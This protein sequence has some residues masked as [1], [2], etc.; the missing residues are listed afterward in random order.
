M[1]PTSHPATDA[2]ASS[3][4]HNESFIDRITRMLPILSGSRL[5]GKRSRRCSF[6]PASARIRIAFSLL[7]AM[8]VIHSL[9]FSRTVTPSFASDTQPDS[10]TAEQETWLQEE[11]LQKIA[12]DNK[13]TVAAINYAYLDVARIWLNSVQDVNATNFALIALDVNAYDALILDYPDNTFMPPYSNL[14]TVSKPVMHGTGEFRTVTC[15]RPRFLLDFLDKG[16]TVF[17]S[18]IDSIWRRNPW[19]VY[20]NAH[21]NTVDIAYTLDGK[22][23]YICSCFL[24]LRPT[25]KTKAAVAKW[26]ELID[27]KQFK[28]DQI[29]FNTMLHMP[30]FKNL[31]TMM[32]DKNEFPSGR[33]MFKT[34]TYDWEVNRNGPSIVHANYMKGHDTKLGVLKEVEQDY[35]K[36]RD[37]GTST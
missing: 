9:C 7:L 29:P 14:T 23:N 18:D 11:R 32:L 27:T 6:I 33:E 24:F 2:N 36:C 31:K 10:Y 30:E 1:G 17:Y 16:Y 8:V 12:V 21:G 37:K 20:E 35:F 3:S 15:T 13:I 34:C 25:N 22:A 19:T 26:R 5:G 4:L 28:G